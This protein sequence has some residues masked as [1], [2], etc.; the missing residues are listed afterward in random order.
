MKTLDTVLAWALVVL[1]VIH[2]AVTFTIRPFSLGTVWFFSAGAAMIMAG[3]LNVIR[4]GSGGKGLVRGSA[5]LAN[6]LLVAMVAGVVW[7]LLHRL[8][9]EPQVIIGAVLA[10]GELLF[11]LRGRR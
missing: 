4:I 1:G 10:V 5:I 11:S 2:C 7:F 9:R 8:T 6:A 3:L